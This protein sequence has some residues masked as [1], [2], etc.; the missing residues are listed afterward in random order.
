MSAKAVH[1]IDSNR[2]HCLS[3]RDAFNFTTSKSAFKSESLNLA[4][5]FRR[6][7]TSLV[8]AAVTVFILAENMIKSKPPSAVFLSMFGADEDGGIREPEAQQIWQLFSLALGVYF[9]REVH[10]SV[11]NMLTDTFLT[12]NCSI[13]YIDSVQSVQPLICTPA[14]QMDDE[15]PIEVDCQSP[16]FEFLLLVH[17]NFLFDDCKR[18][19]KVTLLDENDMQAAFCVQTFFLR[20]NA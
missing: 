11:E 5:F 18:Q 13:F 19:L 14:L 15:R 9:L 16:M 17:S 8:E 2:C 3:F 12:R 4:D 7:V 1:I 6:L 20:G 10:R